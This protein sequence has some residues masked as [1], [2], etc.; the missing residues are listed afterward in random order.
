MEVYGVVQEGD[1]VLRKTA[2]Q[3]PID[4]ISSAHIQ[5]VLLRMKE[6]LEK[7]PDGVA[8]AAPQIGESVRIFIV[9]KSA[10]GE[11]KKHTPLVFINPV[12]TKT[13]RTK[14]WVDEGCLSVRW[15]YGQAHRA[16]RATIEAYDETGAQFSYGGSGLI[17]QIFQ[18]ETDHLDGILFH[19][20]AR[21]VTELTPE[22]IERIHE[23]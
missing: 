14:K 21:D 5:G 2:S 8:L 20:H 1:P 22:E 10:Y 13:S 23:H 16:T 3:V 18:H 9:A 12:I 4:E 6:T 15:K 19:D 7:Q 17:A 11:T